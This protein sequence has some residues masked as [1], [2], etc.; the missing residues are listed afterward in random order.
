MQ[1]A[2]T[3]ELI[4]VGD[5]LTVGQLIELR[6]LI[7]T[8]S[9]SF[10]VGGK[11]GKTDIVEHHIVLEPDAQPVVEPLRRRPLFHKQEAHRRVSKMLREGILEPSE[12]PWASAYVM[13]KKKTGEM[14]MCIDF[15]KL[16]DKTKKN[17]YPLP[18]IEDC[19]EPLS[20]NQYF[21]SLD[22][23]SGYWQI[24]MSDES[25]KFTAFRTEEGLFQF[26]RMP[27]GLCN[28]P[29]SFQR[30]VNALFSGLKGVHLQVFIDDICVAAKT[31]E[32][33][34]ELLSRVFGLLERADLKLKAS[35]C[36]FGAESVIF[37]G[38][39]LSSK[40]IEQDPAKIRAIVKL[41]APKNLIEL[42]RA[43]GLFSY[44]RR[45]VPN[46]SSLAEPLFRLT[47]K[48][49]D[50]E[51][52]GEQEVAFEQ[53]RNSLCKNIILA[54]FNYSDPVALKTDASIQGVA[55]LLLQRQEN[56]WRIITCCS[57][58]LS[59]SK[60]NYGISDLEGLAIIY[61]V[62]KLRN[63][64]LGRHFTIITDYSALR[65]LKSKMPNSPRLRRWAILLSEFDFSIQYAKGGLHKDVDCLSRAPVDDAIDPYLDDKFLSIFLSKRK[66]FSVL[67]S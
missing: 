1:V 28:A 33:H 2:D 54:N 62:S 20:G 43:L 35:E 17:V 10:S 34:L 25:K 58:R 36:T 50:Y 26:T 32:E 47:R 60:M 45:F 5:N 46:F 3:E 52:E 19:I 66:M 55:G 39:K 23:A 16:N 53:L 22:L 15:R 67:L 30:L 57:R 51:W 59:R 27:F 37:L 11:I 12:S 63:Y 4:T 44:Y 56:E 40:G 6:Q 65:S 49:V 14:R 42:R 21:S 9:N 24:K 64:L 18:N 38:H 61:A 7:G 29:A 41:P 31:W 13:V 8:H 48:N